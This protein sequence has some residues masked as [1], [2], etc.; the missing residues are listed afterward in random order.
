MHEV[1]TTS[2]LPTHDQEMIIAGPRAIGAVRRERW[3]EDGVHPVYAVGNGGLVIVTGA[4]VMAPAVL[5]VVLTTTFLV[6]GCATVSRR[7]P[8]P[9]CCAAVPI[10]FPSTVRVVTQTPRAFELQSAQILKHVH[11]AAG[12]SPVNVL[13]LSG[14][15]AGGAFG[16]GVL[17]G[18]SRAGERPEYQIVT[19]VS[20]GAL[21]APFA[22][23]ARPGTDSW[24]R[25]SPRAAP[26][27]C[28]NPASRAGYTGSATYSERVSIGASRWPISL[29]GSPQA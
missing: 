8:L 14:G 10:G 19:G 9:I 11:G 13:V 12:G 6:A 3:S 22:F 2:R 16:A 17:V 7:P 24:S 28:C 26:N 18:L 27:I 25:P 5:C 1:A 29:I 20:V 23:L 4:F 21:I 15:G